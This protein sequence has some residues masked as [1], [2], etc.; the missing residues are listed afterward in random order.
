[1]FSFK[2]SPRPNTLAIKRLPDDVP[3]AEKTRRI[4]AVQ[5]LQ[6]EIQL[7]WHERAVGQV[8]EVLVDA[9]SRRR[10]HELAGRTSGNTVVNFPGPP[11]WLN[12]LQPVRI[13]AAA[14]N[15]LRGEAVHADAAVAR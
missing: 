9:A 4:V 3:E 1:M 2:Y 15:S 14:P 10:G 7:E 6:A 11:E 13:T 12:T 5:R 8:F